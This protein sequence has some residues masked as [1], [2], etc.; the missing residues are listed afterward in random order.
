MNIKIFAKTDIPFL[1]LGIRRGP[2]SESDCSSY[3]GIVEYC[4]FGK[5]HEGF[6]F[7]HAKFR[8]NKIL[9]KW[10]NHSVDYLYS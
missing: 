10:R 5:F 6:I 8:E 7:A 4:K 9:A 1:L 2:L 3:T